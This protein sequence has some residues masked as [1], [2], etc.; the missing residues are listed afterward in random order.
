MAIERW[1]IDTPHSGIHFTVRH[2]VIAKVR[3]RF[4]RWHGS[5]VFE[6]THPAN[7]KV[8]VQTELASIDT[9]EPKR[10]EHLRSA[11]FLDEIAITLAARRYVGARAE[12]AA[13]LA[14]SCDEGRGARSG[15]DG[16]LPWH[17]S[18]HVSGR[19]RVLTMP[20]LLTHSANHRRRLRNVLAKDRPLLAPASHDALSARLVEQARFEAVYMRRFCNRPSY[21]GVR[22][23]EQ[24]FMGDFDCD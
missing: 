22:T 1:T 19:Q 2:M 14:S 23:D 13:A 20:G 15:T 12:M 24:D 8:S 18:C 16:R 21:S 17:G 6:E 4:D 11:D 10:D 9:H 5:L 3:G 7:S